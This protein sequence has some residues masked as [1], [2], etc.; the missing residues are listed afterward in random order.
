MLA[1]LCPKEVQKGARQ[2]AKASASAG[3]LGRAGAE[4]LTVVFYPCHDAVRA[5]W[6]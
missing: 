4:E 2:S 5:W 3:V 6:M 1:P